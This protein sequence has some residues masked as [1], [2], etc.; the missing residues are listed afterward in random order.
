MYAIIQRDAKVSRHHSETA[1]A[2]HVVAVQT[3]FFAYRVQHLIGALNLLANYRLLFA[4]NCVEKNEK[5][6]GAR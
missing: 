3:L 4:T 5:E 1:L 2:Q 6:L